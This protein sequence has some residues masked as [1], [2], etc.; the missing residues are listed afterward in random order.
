MADAYIECVGC[1]PRLQG[2]ANRTRVSRGQIA[3]TQNF[4][5]SRLEKFSLPL[6]WDIRHIH[7]APRRILLCIFVLH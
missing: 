7:N 1:P 6:C 3:H 5:D 4:V 2:E